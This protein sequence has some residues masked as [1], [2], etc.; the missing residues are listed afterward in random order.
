MSKIWS[1]QAGTISGTG[2]ILSINKG[3]LL[4]DDKRL[5]YAPCTRFLSGGLPSLGDEVQYTAYDDG[6]AVWIQEVRIRK[7]APKPSR[8]TGMVQQTMKSV[9]SEIFSK[10]TE[11]KVQYPKRMI[12]LPEQDAN[13]T[14]V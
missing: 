11:P 2:K 1:C 10:S 8:V 9:I 12:L 6:K 14:S 3:L 4:I 5:K 13:Q 7:A